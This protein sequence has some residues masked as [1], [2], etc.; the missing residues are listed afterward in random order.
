MRYDLSHPD[1]RF[2]LGTHLS[3]GQW[4][5]GCRYAALG[6]TQVC[7]DDAPVQSPTMAGECR[8]LRHRPIAA[9]S[10]CDGPALSVPETVV[11]API[12]RVVAQ[13]RWNAWVFDVKPV[14][15][16]RFWWTVHPITLDAIVIY[17]L[18]WDCKSPVSQ[19]VS[20]PFSRSAT[21]CHP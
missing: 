14:R 12:S 1:F 4:R 8:I 5:C 7:W 20:P 6:A 11:I 10:H 18:D 17:W 3:A 21:T 9:S 19:G 2:H 16:I 15:P 13:A